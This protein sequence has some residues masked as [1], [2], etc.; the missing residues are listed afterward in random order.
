MNVFISEGVL[1]TPE[2][3]GGQDINFMDKDNDLRIDRALPTASRLM[4]APDV[5]KVKSGAGNVNDA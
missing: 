4:A 1:T 5:K 3:M 2:E